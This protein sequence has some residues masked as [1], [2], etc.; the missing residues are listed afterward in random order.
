MNA[1]RVTRDSPS[2][3]AVG[4]L[5][6]MGTWVWNEATP[7]TELLDG[8]DGALSPA[9]LSAQ[10]VRRA[11]LCSVRSRMFLWVS[12]YPDLKT[13][14]AYGVLDRER[15]LAQR[16]YFI[17]DKQGVLRY[18]NVLGRGHPL[19]PNDLLVEEIKKFQ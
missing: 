3:I 17:M 1:G 9:S 13:T 4:L 11:L 19:I 14:A 16:S 18:K 8:S 15:G 2:M 7:N 12:D 5:D 6:L 10:L